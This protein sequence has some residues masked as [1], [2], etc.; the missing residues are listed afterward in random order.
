M[1]GKPLRKFPTGPPSG[2]LDRFSTCEPSL[3]CM[4]IATGSVANIYMPGAVAS[5]CARR[6]RPR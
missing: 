5:H 4:G 6:T 2:N 1:P 3:F